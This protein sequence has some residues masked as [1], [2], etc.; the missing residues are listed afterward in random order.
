MTVQ[1]QI[2]LWEL[3]K[4]RLKSADGKRLNAVRNET[5]HHVHHRVRILIHELL[6]T[7]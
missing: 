3:E 2:R 6:L 4:N 1:D 5:T 7:R